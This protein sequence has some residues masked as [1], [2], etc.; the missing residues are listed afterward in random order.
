MGL[1]TV[2]GWGR[3]SK[4]VRQ[5]TLRGHRVGDRVGGGH[6]GKGIWEWYLDWRKDVVWKSQQE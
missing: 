1:R 5:L 3:D 4:R 6:R 2:L